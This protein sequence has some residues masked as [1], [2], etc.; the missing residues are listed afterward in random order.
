MI[1]KWGFR[2]F[3]VKYDSQNSSTLFTEI[4]LSEYLRPIRYDGSQLRSLTGADPWVGISE[5]VLVNH[6]TVLILRIWTDRLGKQCRPRSDAAECGVWSGSTLFATH[7]ALLHIFTGS[8][9]DL[10]KRSLRKSIPNVSF[11]FSN[12]PWKWYFE[13]KTCSTEPTNPP[14]PPPPPHPHPS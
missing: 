1:R 12:F 14:P 9:I 8:E 6:I 13:S 7:P 4:C 2:I 10:L 5:G 3:K 11:F